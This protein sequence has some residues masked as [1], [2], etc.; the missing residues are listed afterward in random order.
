MAEQINAGAPAEDNAAP[1]RLIEIGA[2]EM[3]TP[4]LEKI[5]DIFILEKKARHDGDNAKLTELCKEVVS[6]AAD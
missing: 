1:Q 2:E 6:T 5:N 4:F 3:W